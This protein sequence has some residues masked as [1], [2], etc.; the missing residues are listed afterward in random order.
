MLQISFITTGS[1]VVALKRGERL[2][3]YVNMDSNPSP[4]YGHWSGHFSS[5]LWSAEC[6]VESIWTQFVNKTP[7]KIVYLKI[8]SIII[9]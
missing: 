8:T 6:N 2:N 4:R 3:N 9:G 1:P 5:F 7:N